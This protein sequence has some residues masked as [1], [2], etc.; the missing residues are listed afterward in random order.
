MKRTILAAVAVVGSLALLPVS[1][2]AQGIAR[3]GTGNALAGGLSGFHGGGFHGG[4]ALAG[5]GIR[6]GALG[7]GFHGGLAGGRFRGGFGNGNALAGGG[8]G[9]FGGRHFGVAG[10]GAIN[11]GFG[12]HRGFRNAGFVGHRGFAGRGFYRGRGYG[13]GGLGLGVGLGLAGAG[14]GYG[15]GP[16]DDGYYGTEYGPAGY[17]YGYAP[18]GYGPAVGATETVVTSSGSSDSYC[19]RRFRSYDPLSGTYLGYDGRRHACR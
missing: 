18:V 2:E 12:G 15:Y 9:H 4:G 8:V 5:G 7:G 13:Y 6:G 14:L 11:H 10:A 3:G 1:A 16:F 19:A 17:G